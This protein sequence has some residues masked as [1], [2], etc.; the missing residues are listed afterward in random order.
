M[1]LDKGIIQKSILVVQRTDEMEIQWL[2]QWHE[3]LTPAVG[4]KY[5]QTISSQGGGR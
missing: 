3:M 1:W 4:P 2:A 5:S